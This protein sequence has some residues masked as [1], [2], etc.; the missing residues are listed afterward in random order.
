M[1]RCVRLSAERCVDGCRID[2]RR[3]WAALR[4]GRGVGGEWLNLRRA[5]KVVLLWSAQRIWE[6]LSSRSDSGL[7]LLQHQSRGAALGL[8]IKPIAVWADTLLPFKRQL[9][10]GHRLNHEAGKEH[11]TSQ[12]RGSQ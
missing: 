7:Q 1:V 5:E 2:S 10:G 3:G 4:C 6:E 11:F 9:R 8:W 12:C